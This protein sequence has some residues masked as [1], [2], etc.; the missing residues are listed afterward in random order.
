MSWLRI[1]RPTALAACLILA[2]PASG[3]TVVNPEVVPLTVEPGIEITIRAANGLV[4]TKPDTERATD[5]LGQRLRLIG[6]GNFSMSAGNDITVEVP[7]TIDIKKVRAAVT[8]SGVVAF[9]ALPADTTLPDVGSSLAVTAPLWD[10]DQVEQASFG[11]D[12]SGAQTVSIV[13]RPIAAAAFAAYAAAHVNQAFVM[14]LDGKV[15]AAP[16]I[17]F[18]IPDGH[19]VLTF[20]DPLLLP[21]DVLAAILMSGPLPEAWRQ[22]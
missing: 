11:T 14:T 22:P 4:P 19:I 16:V 9:G 8:A 6:V 2:I 12:E 10:G 7:A 21:T 18:P 17:R 20:G 13:L 1:R 5:I 15:V 3:C